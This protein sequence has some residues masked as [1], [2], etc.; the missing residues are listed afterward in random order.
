MIEGAAYGAE[1]R[2]LQCQRKDQLR[3]GDVAMGG[4]GRL[5]IIDEAPDSVEH[6][7]R[8]LPCNEAAD[9]A[10]RDEQDLVHAL[11]SWVT[12]PSRY[13]FAIQAARKTSG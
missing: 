1:D 6:R 3:P 7:L 10:E 2:T 13:R 12:I 9:H 11:A 8:E 4:L 5:P